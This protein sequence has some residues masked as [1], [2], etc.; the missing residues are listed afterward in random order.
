MRKIDARQFLQVTNLESDSMNKIGGLPKVDGVLWWW[1]LLIFM[2]GASVAWCLEVDREKGKE[3]ERENC[4]ENHFQFLMDAVH[5]AATLRTKLPCRKI[6][7]FNILEQIKLLNR[8]CDCN[9]LA[10]SMQ[11]VEYIVWR[12][13]AAFKY[14]YSTNCEEMHWMAH[15]D[16]RMKDDLHHAHIYDRRRRNTILTRQQENMWNKW[17]LWASYCRASNILTLLLLHFCFFF[18]FGLVCLLQCHFLSR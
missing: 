1:K 6:F 4:S 14:F 3:R 2:S 7:R 8:V 10:C 17:N 16:Q 11:N 12:Q 9:G 18:R 5:S 15:R 13:M